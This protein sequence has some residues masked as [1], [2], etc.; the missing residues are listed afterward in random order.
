MTQINTPYP[1]TAYLTGFLRSQGFE[2]I[3]A[4]PALELVL[5]L[6]N[7]TGLETISQELKTNK[8]I[9][10]SLKHFLKF[11]E[12]YIN[13][14]FQGIIFITIK[15]FLKNHRILKAISL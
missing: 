8:V 11:K 12:N 2:A 1:A 3:Q 7:K 15:Q 5:K 10:P 4:D 9:A 13:F 14:K 6:L